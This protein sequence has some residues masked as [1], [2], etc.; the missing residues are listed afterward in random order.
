MFTKFEFQKKKINEWTS[1]DW[2]SFQEA[3]R[4]LQEKWEQKERSMGG[5]TAKYYE[6]PLVKLGFLDLVGPQQVKVDWLPIQQGGQPG[7]YYAAVSVAIL[8]GYWK[9]NFFQCLCALPVGIGE[10]ELSKTPAH[11]LKCAYTD[12]FVNAVRDWLGIGNV[13][14]ETEEGQKKEETTKL[15]KQTQ[16]LQQNISFTTLKRPGDGGAAQINETQRAHIADLLCEIS[17]NE[18]IMVLSFII[19]RAFSQKPDGALYF[20]KTITYSE[21][22]FAINQLETKKDE[23]FGGCEKNFG[24]TLGN[25]TVL[26]D[27]TKSGWENSKC[28]FEKGLG[29]TWLQL[30]QDCDLEKGRKSREYLEK[31]LYKSYRKDIK[32]VAAAA[33]ALVKVGEKNP[34]MQSTG[35]RVD[36]TPENLD[37]TLDTVGAKP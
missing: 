28:T 20:E 31:L 19:G 1:E 5:W 23:I 17:G 32:A 7:N 37:R 30:A 24:I 10:K 2:F 9:D 36:T 14:E 34:K 6:A 8:L 26:P 12:A 21:A 3:C 4:K 11:A 25:K 33:L 22:N 16:N 27:I 29:K 15:Q 35:H 13:E 18:Q